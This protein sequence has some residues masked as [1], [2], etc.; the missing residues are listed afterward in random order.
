MLCLPYYAYALFSTKTIRAERDLPET[1]E[2][3]GAN[4][5]EWSRV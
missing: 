5:G 3:K 2:G 1:E 4:V